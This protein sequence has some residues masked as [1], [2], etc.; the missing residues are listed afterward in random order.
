MAEPVEHIYLCQDGTEIPLSWRTSSRNRNIRLTVA[1]SGVRISTPP[2]TPWSMVEKFLRSQEVWLKAHLERQTPE[3]PNTLLYQGA[4]YHLQISQNDNQKRVHLREDTCYVSPIS[5]TADSAFQTLERWLRSEAATQLTP[6]FLEC[7]Q[8]M[9]TQAGQLR[10][11][12]TRSRW[13]SC[14]SDGEIMLSWRLI[15]APVEVARYVIIHELA[16]RTHHNH[17]SHFWKLVAQ[18]DPAYKLHRGWLKRHGHECQTPGF[19]Q[20]INN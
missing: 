6:V 3:A 9:D 18:Y 5:L 7:R 11:R 19:E 4:M 13:G 20:L 10:W 1:S 12:D 16:H 8:L 15:H 14:S 2:R 17:S